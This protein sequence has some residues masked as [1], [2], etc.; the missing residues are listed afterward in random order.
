MQVR[1][2]LQ[3]KE[4]LDQRMGCVI[5]GPCGCG[6]SSVWGVLRAAMIK[7]GQVCHNFEHIL[8][9]VLCMYLDVAVCDTD[10]VANYRISCK[11]TAY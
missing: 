3:L 8:Q 1:K 10:S 6:K 5:V 4:S 9:V 2:M 11:C 7:C